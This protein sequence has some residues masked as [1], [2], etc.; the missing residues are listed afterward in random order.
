MPACF[1]PVVA[2]MSIQLSSLG[3]D[4]YSSY[5]RLRCESPVVYVE[6]LDLWFV[7]RWADVQDLE[8]T[9]RFTAAVRGSALTRTIGPNMLHADGPEHRRLREAVAPVLRPGPLRSWAEGPLSEIAADLLAAIDEGEVDLMSALAEPLPVK[10]LAHLIGLEGVPFSR[11]RTWFLGIG[12]GAANFSADRVVQADADAASADV[13]G[14]LRPFLTGAEKPRSGSLL[15]ALLETGE[16]LTE[17][18]VSGTVK[19]MIIGGMQ[20]PRDLIGTAVQVLLQDPHLQA[21]VRADGRLV[22]RLLEECLRWNSPVGT[23]T[24][25]ATVPTVVGGVQIPAGARLAGV[26][27]SAN[28]DESRWPDPD[29]FDVD[30]VGPTHT[31]FAL[32]VHSCVGAGLSRLVARLAIEALLAEFA[33]MT[34]VGRIEQRGWEFR[35]P[36]ALPAEVERWRLP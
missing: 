33:R 11:L 1:A 29:V 20:E 10:A 32:G 14:A 9:S 24:R 28:R 5:R 31:A 15:H 8:D 22:P 2:D 30:R 6:E 12:A 25:M 7:T 27:A 18:D 4:P 35:G 19:L 26:L 3:E 36:V 34:A 17:S 21:R 13:D 23:I 16:S